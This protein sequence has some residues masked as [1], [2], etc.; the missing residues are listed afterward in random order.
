MVTRDRTLI[1]AR[2]MNQKLKL[3]LVNIRFEMKRLARKI[4]FF[5]S[6]MDDLGGFF[7]FWIDRK[8]SFLSFFFLFCFWLDTVGSE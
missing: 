2:R 6:V 3:E 7:C 5:F 4:Q 1:M 8:E